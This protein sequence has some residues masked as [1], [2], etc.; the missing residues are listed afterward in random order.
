MGIIS[1]L[2]SEAHARTALSAS[3]V[4]VVGADVKAS[5]KIITGFALFPLMCGVVATVVY[6]YTDSFRSAATVFLATPMAMYVSL[7]LVHEFILEL[8]AALPLFISLVSNHKQFIKLHERRTRLVAM[9]REMVSKFD[10]SL[11]SEMSVYEGVSSPTGPA[12][13]FFSL[14]HRSRASPGVAAN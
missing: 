3:S 8:Y 5:Y 6:H 12:P 4:K 10:P 13:S 9:A 11:D 2:A 14:R 7:H 1:Q